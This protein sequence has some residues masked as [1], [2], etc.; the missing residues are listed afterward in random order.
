MTFVFHLAEV[1]P[2]G[3]QCPFDF[4]KVCR[5]DF[6]LL[7]VQKVST[8]EVSLLLGD[9][10]SLPCEAFEVLQKGCLPTGLKNFLGERTT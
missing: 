5:L 6:L 4:Y 3:I 7:E 1:S 9:Y 2:P 10:Q 8:I